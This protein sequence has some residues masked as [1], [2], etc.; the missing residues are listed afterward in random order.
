[1]RSRP[2]GAKAG[3]NTSGLAVCIRAMSTAEWHASSQIV[4]RRWKKHQAKFVC[5][6]R[7]PVPR[8]Y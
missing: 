7:R 1:M 8:G 6:A 2:R 3:L 5:P 4:R